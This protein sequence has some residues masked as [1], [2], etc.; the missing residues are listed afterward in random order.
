MEHSKTGIK[1]RTDWLVCGHSG[2]PFPGLIRRTAGRK[3]PTSRLQWS[4]ESIV[5]AMCFRPFKP[6]APPD[7]VVVL[8]AS[9]TEEQIYFAIVAIEGQNEHNP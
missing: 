3:L 1:F 5:I 9:V 2:I 6:Q 8:Y 7:W 4:Y